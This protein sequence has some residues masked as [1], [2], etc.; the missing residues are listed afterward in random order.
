MSL[1][2]VVLIV[3]AA[4]TASLRGHI[5]PMGITVDAKEDVTMKT[6]LSSRGKLRNLALLVAF[7]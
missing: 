3:V 2:I 7:L 6:R 1:F 5:I 4:A